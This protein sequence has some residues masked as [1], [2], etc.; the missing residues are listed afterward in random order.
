MRLNIARAW[1]LIMI[2]AFYGQVGRN[3]E[4]CEKQIILVLQNCQIKTIFS[5]LLLINFAIH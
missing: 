2:L 1:S 4:G 3:L 5:T